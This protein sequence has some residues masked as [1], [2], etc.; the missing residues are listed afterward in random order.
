M[1]NCCAMKYYVDLPK[2][3]K[4]VMYPYLHFNLVVC[5][6]LRI[7]VLGMGALSSVCYK[8]GRFTTNHDIFAFDGVSRDVIE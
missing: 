8:K 7:L 1:M 5:L 3:M 2:E 6:W 4:L